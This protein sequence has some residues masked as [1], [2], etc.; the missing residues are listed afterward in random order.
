MVSIADYRLVMDR[1][2]ERSARR[3]FMD[4]RDATLYVSALLGSTLEISGVLAVGPRSRVTMHSPYFW[5]RI[6]DE[7]RAPQLSPKQATYFAYYRDPLQDDPRLSGQYF[8]TYEEAASAE[9][10]LSKDEFR[11]AIE[12]GSLRLSKYLPG[13]VPYRFV[14]A[15]TTLAK[16]THRQ[17]MKKALRQITIALTKGRRSFLGKTRL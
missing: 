17:E 13:I 6:L 14:D 8:R 5:S 4:L 11:S 3:T 12:S 15:G 1:A 16:H 7:G 2:L 9:L 10:S